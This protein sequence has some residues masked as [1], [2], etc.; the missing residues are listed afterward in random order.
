MLKKFCYKFRYFFVC[1][2][3]LGSFFSARCVAAHNQANHKKNDITIVVDAGHGGADPGKV[4]VDNI[5]EKDVNLAIAKKLEKLLKKKGYNVIMTRTDDS[6]LASPDSTK[7]KI[8]DLQNRIKLIE[9]NNADLTVCIHQNSFPDESIFG[10]QV[11]YYSNSTYSEELAKLVQ[12]E[13]DENLDI[14]NSRQVKDNPDY[15]LLRKSPTPTIIVECGF[16]S[17]PTE[18]KLLIDDSYQNKLS[19]AIYLGIYK[20]IKRNY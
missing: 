17:N 9:D 20:F 10:P 6:D 2:I 1:M 7:R 18:A 4:G 16:L 19:R 5:L 11:F 12:T 8:E 15:Y 13:V 14:K 3:F